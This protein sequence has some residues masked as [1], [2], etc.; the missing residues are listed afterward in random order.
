VEIP[1]GRFLGLFSSFGSSTASSRHAAVVEDLIKELSR[2]RKEVSGEYQ[3]L[4]ERKEGGGVDEKV[5]PTAQTMKRRRLLYLLMKDLSSGV[6]GDVIANKVQRDSVAMAMRINRVPRSKK[7]FGWLFVG[8]L[9]F[10]ML[11]YVYLFALNQTH[12][13][14]AAWFQSFLLWVVFEIIVSSTGLVVLVH[15]LIPLYVL[16]DVCKLKEKV[17]GSVISFRERFSSATQLNSP[18]DT[19]FNAAK[20]LF[21]SWR[22]ASL[23]HEKSR[24]NGEARDTDSILPET[25]L[26]L[27]FSTPWPSKRLGG[28]DGE[29]AQEYEEDIVLAA[30]A[31][32][33]TYFLGSLL[34]FHIL[35]QEIVVQ[36][37]WTS[38]IGYLVVWL[39]QLWRVHPLLPLVPVL[40][41]S[42]VIFAFLRLLWQRDERVQRLEMI[43]PIKEHRP[44]PPPVAHVDPEDPISEPDRSEGFGGFLVD[45]V[46][47]SE[48]SDNRSLSDDSADEEKE[49]GDSSSEEVVIV[50]AIPL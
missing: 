45:N 7:F 32:I 8:L 20:Y 3:W 12:S 50:R 23:L 47:A 15:L 46:G 10:G 33:A 26:I 27:H 38:G 37:L 34:S 49:S 30:V 5:H 35:V 22:V 24:T 21:T 44:T 4:S 14:Q 48:S 16:N 18:P 29:V 2:V 11:F 19:E 42:M 17:L 40:I 39:I 41:I 28:R 13:R 1:R 25:A 6:S 36:M 9:N 43:H 31:R